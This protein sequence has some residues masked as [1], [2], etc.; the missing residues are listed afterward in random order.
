MIESILCLKSINQS[1]YKFFLV[2]FSPTRIQS[3]STETRKKIQNE[4]ENSL[5]HHHHQLENKITNPIQA[6]NQS[7]RLFNNTKQQQTTTYIIRFF[8]KQ[9]LL[10]KQ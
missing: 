3:P 8:N 7:Y 5:K 4:N 9:Q 6:Y 10:H 1:Y 2:S